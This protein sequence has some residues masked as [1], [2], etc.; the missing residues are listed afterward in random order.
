MNLTPLV[1]IL[2]I[3]NTFNI[4]IIDLIDRNL[5]DITEV[6]NLEYENNLFLEKCWKIENVEIEKNQF[7]YA[8]SKGGAVKIPDY[9]FY[10]VLEQYEYIKLQIENTL[11]ILNEIKF[12]LITENKK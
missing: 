8:A 6:E 10:E 3:E 7:E 5:N 11:K 1:K 4:S 9:N 12:N 2:K